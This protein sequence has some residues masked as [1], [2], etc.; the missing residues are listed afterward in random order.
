MLRG[1]RVRG[2]RAPLGPLSAHSRAPPHGSS[3]DPPSGILRGLITPGWII[4]VGGK[5]N[6]QLLAR[7]QL[8]S[9]A[10]TGRWISQS[11]L[12]A[13]TPIVVDAKA[14]CL[15]APPAGPQH[16]SRR[17]SAVPAVG[18]HC[19]A[20]VLLLRGLRLSH[21]VMEVGLSLNSCRFLLG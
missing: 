12:A 19:S 11:R 16:L 10:S 17:R 7:A 8:K 3:E 15:P 13:D 2:F 4:P 21:A 14:S 20:S 5:V 9:G 6:R 18:A 1:A